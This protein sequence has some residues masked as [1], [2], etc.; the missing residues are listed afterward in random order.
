VERKIKFDI[1]VKSVVTVVAVLGLFALLF[2]VKDIL[3]LFLIAFIM[4]TALEPLVNWLEMKHIPRG[5]TVVGIFVLVGLSLYTIV[6]L[7]IPP[8]TDQVNALISSRQVIVERINSYLSHAPANVKTGLQDF[9]NLLPEKLTGFTSGTLVT[10][11]FGVVTGLFAVL[12]VL[13]TIFYLLMEKNIMEKAIKFFW[14]SNSEERALSVFKN[15]GTKI[16][17]WARGQIILSTSVGM[18]TFL[19]LSILKFEYALVLALVAA[20]MDLIPFI[21]PTITMVL[22]VS[23]AFAY[24][25]MYALWV[26]LLFFGIQQ[27]EA[28]VLVPQIM[29]RAVG[30]SPVITIFAILIGAKLLGL[31]G[32]V[33][34]VPV[35]SVIIVILEELNKKGKK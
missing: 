20:F 34:A 33:I 5:I 6:R 8:I 15:I 23:L 24:S 16:S 27:F 21:G 19:G 32:V 17:S 14:P 31:I 11:V 22:G 30:I 25:P 4:A 35:A 29:K 12:T 13:V 3:V 7:M 9:V 18:L 26:A 28:H 10:S 1:T 2:F